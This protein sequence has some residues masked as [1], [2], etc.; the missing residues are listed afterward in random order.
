MYRKNVGD[1][2]TRDD[3]DGALRRN[4]LCRSII[5]RITAQS[6]WPGLAWPRDRTNH[7]D[8]KDASGGIFESLYIKEKCVIRRRKSRAPCK[9]T[10]RD[11][12]MHVTWPNATPV[13]SAPDDISDP[14]PEIATGK[15]PE[16]VEGR[17]EV[18][19]FKN[20][21][22]RS[23]IVWGM[24]QVLSHFAVSIRTPLPKESLQESDVCL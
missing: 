3:T 18:L 11:R 10:I 4:R 9:P 14:R 24:P 1:R 16:I 19:G 15:S 8:A 13:S 22:R 21:L 2:N 17:V 23:C 5:P 6:P 12:D 7:C 20:Q